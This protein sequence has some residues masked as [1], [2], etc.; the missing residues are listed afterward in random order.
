[1]DTA[2][3]TACG[4][5]LATL[6]SAGLALR[7]TREARR[8]AKV[9]GELQADLARLNS[10]L[11]NERVR[12]EQ[13]LGRELDA[14][15]LLARYREP[16]AAAAFDLQSR[17]WNIV[18]KDFFSKRF[19]REHE[20]F[21]DAQMTTL[22]RFAQYFGWA[23]IL[24][25]EIQY[26]SFPEEQDTRC[27]TGLLTK[28]AARVAA[29]DDDETLMIWADEQRAIGERMIVHEGDGVRC[30][31]YAA[32]RDAY[33]ACFAQLFARVIDDLDEPAAVPRLRD[34]QHDLCELV[35]QLDKKRLRY[36]DTQLGRA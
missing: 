36:S 30:M 25:R 21:P 4:G 34:V 19:G 28:V 20:R 6:V 29:S 11:A 24:R 14:E 7:Q 23:E 31:G 8:L 16:L 17:C 18:R 27:V 15:D 22:F 33:E 10:D 12:F 5:I 13:E 35:G 1:M 9:N 32:F 3:V 2:V 26:L